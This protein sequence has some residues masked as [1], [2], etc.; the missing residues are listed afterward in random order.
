MDDKVKAGLDSGRVVSVVNP[1][2]GI[3]PLLIGEGVPTR[4]NANVGG[5]PHKTDVAAEVEKAKVAVEAGADAVMDLTVGGNMEGM[6]DAIIKAVD[7]SVGTVPI[8]EAFLKNEL[9]LTLEDFLKVL[10]RQARAGVDFFTI[11]S[12]L[13]REGMEL[14]QK[15]VI[16][17]TSRGG[18]FIAAW[19]QKHGQESFLYTGFDEILEILKEHEVVVSLGDGLRPG[20]LAD[21]TDDAQL[22]EL[23]KLGE[24]VGRC[25]A[26]GVGV[27]VEGPG[28]VPLDQIQK[29]MELQKDICQGAPFYVLG[30]LVTDIALGYDHITGAI[31]GALAALYGADFLCYVTPSEHLGLPD[32]EDV[33]KG[34][35]ASKIA[36][37]AADVVKLGDRS[38]DDEL[39]KA[40]AE[41]DWDKMFEL[42]LDPTVRDRFPEDSG[43]DPCS[44]CGEYCALKII[45]KK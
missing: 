41:L 6:L 34:V 10:E 3:E 8:Y 45:S 40:R 39:S 23:K 19:M 14:A 16:P 36:A 13:T 37:H 43:R 32:L 2:R 20:A 4:V 9:D 18:S 1:R 33:K 7:V 35:I 21:A 44:M 22:H 38:R 5:S 42:C 26:A 15:R 25:R 29:N 28:H 11:H 30:P 12:G 31:G 24:L 17:V 27:I